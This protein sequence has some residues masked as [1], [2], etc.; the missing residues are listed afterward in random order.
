MEVERPEFRRLLQYVYHRDPKLEIASARTAERRISDMGTK[1]QEDLK[2]FF[3][4][5]F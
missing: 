1:L 5:R 3:A 2:S 4:V